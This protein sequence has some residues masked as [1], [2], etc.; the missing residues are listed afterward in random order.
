MKN[1]DALRGAHWLVLVIGLC[2][3]L[4]AWESARR[5]SVKILQEEF[6]YRVHQVVGRIERRFQESGMIL[7][8]SAGLFGASK[9][10][11]LHDPSPL[12]VPRG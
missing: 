4:L 3:T 11:T 8:G 7:R 12:S 1:Q 5:D 10:V 9:E 2:A 6:D